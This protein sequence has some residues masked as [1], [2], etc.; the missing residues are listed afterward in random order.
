MFLASAVGRGQSAV[1]AYHARHVGPAAGKLQHAGAAET[2]ADRRHP[3][4]IAERFAAKRVEART[5]RS[6]ISLGFFL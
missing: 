3:L 4:G 6:R 1:E 5:D 2:V